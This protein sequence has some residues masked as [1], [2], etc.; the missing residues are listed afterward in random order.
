MAHKQTR[1]GRLVRSVTHKPE[2]RTPISEDMYLPNHSGVHHNLK[3]TGLVA[4]RLVTKTTTYTA[5][6]EDHTILCGPGNETFT[7]TL[8]TA[9]AVTGQVLNIKN[10]GTGTITVDGNGSETIDEGTTAIIN[11]QYESISIHSDGSNWHIL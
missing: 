11:T 9:S 4:L 8:P 3:T 7:V 1:E 5:L 2:I 10:I 6:P